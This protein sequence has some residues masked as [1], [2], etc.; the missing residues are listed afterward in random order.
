MIGVA[1]PGATVKLFKNPSCSGTPDAVGSAAGLADPGLRIFVPRD[2]TTEIAGIATDRAGNLS[3]CSQPISYVEHTRCAGRLATKVG[4]GAVDVISGTRGRDV[5]AGGRGNDTLR[6]LRGRDI[7]CGGP[8]AD[9]LKGGRGDD[10]LFGG[11]GRDTLLGGAGRNI[12]Y[13]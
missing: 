7:I 3:A 10:R 4:T 11:R 1:E 9:T 2:S 5:I 13:Q 12:K 8:G 6:G